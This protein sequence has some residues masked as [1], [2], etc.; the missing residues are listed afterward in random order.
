MSLRTL[1]P[2]LVA[3]HSTKPFCYG[4][5]RAEARRQR[6]YCSATGAGVGLVS[7]CRFVRFAAYLL[8]CS[9]SA[10]HFC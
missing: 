7:Q 2:L 1:R 8:W 9:G 3:S 10:P 4:V 5:L 6:L